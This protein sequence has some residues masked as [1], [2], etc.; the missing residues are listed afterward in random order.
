[1]FAV[2]WRKSFGGENFVGLIALAKTSHV[3]VVYLPATC[4][5][6]LWY[7]RNVEKTKYRL[8]TLRNRWDR[9]GQ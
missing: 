9:K 7:G 1:M 2:L 6:L 8:F 3:T 4:D 5:Y